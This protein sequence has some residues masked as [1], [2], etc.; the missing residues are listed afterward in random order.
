MAAAEWRS[1][2]RGCRALAEQP[3]CISEEQEDGEGAWQ[4]GPPERPRAGLIYDRLQKLFNDT[5]SNLSWEFLDGFKGSMDSPAQLQSAANKMF[6][7]LYAQSPSDDSILALLTNRKHRLPEL[8]EMCVLNVADTVPGLSP[9]A[10][11]QAVH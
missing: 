9:D 6:D 1:Q 11:I 8:V 2:G 3:R 5:V 7:C 4:L 10:L